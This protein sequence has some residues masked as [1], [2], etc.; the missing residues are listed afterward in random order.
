MA[1]CKG[2]ACCQ[3]MKQ[4]MHGLQHVAAKDSRRQ[5]HESNQAL[6]AAKLAAVDCLLWQTDFLRQQG[7]AQSPSGLFTSLRTPSRHSESDSALTSPILSLTA[8][9]VWV[10]ISH[11]HACI[12]L[13]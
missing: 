9:C 1:A 7:S 8:C 11:I 13:A 5:Q 12:S 2:L 10:F 6:K 3:C 4:S